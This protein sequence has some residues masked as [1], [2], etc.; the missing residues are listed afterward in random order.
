M[1]LKLIKENAKHE[2][3]NGAT[4]DGASYN[5]PGKHFQ[6]TKANGV[7]SVHKLSL[8]AN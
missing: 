3:N 2:K 8:V 6:A 5:I 4:N 7:F 1:I